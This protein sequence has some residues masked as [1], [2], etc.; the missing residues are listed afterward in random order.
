MKIEEVIERL[1][2]ILSDYKKDEL[3]FLYAKDMEALETAIEILRRTDN[4]AV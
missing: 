3:N 1:T 4:E 2:A